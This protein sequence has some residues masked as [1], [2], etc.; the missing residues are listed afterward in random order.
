M[1][2]SHYLLFDK[3][4]LVATPESLT[5]VRSLDVTRDG[6]SNVN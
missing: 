4:F 3:I 5:E 2:S 6:A 1:I